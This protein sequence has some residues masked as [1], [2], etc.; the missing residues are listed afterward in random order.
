M[1]QSHT[2]FLA[3]DLE[4]NQPSGRIIQVGAAIGQVGQTAPYFTVRQ[5]LINPGEPIAPE[6]TA[7]TGISDALLEAEAVP[8]CQVALELGALIQEYNPFVNPVTWGGGDSALLLDCF[9][10]AG[11]D[12]PHFGR[13]WIDIKTW[14]VMKELSRGVSPAGGLRKAMAKYGLQ[15]QG[16]PHRA[17]VDAFNTLRL[18]FKMLEWHQ[19]VD[20][21]H[22][23]A[24]A[25]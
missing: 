5:W 3:L 21:I 12:F 7:L 24:Q 20:Q 13:R 2:T 1:A 9:R 19:R 23:L 8:L 14:H 18:F 16:L 4:M 22:A 25:R 17:D 6:I 15:F 10:S 11:I